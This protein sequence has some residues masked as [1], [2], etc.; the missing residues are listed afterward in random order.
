MCDRPP[1][2]RRL[3]DMPPAQQAGILCHDERFQGYVG[4]HCLGLK[5]AVW[6]NEI[7]K[8]GDVA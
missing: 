8:L 7:G 5:W 3:S 4:R 6:G 1:T 2:R